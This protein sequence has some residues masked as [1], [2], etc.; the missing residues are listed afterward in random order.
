MTVLTVQRAWRIM[1]ARG[2]NTGGWRRRWRGGDCRRD[3]KWGV[4]ERGGGGG[5]EER[6]REVALRDVPGE[7][8][9]GL[10]RH[11]SEDKQRVTWPRPAARYGGG[12][13]ALA[14]HTHTHTHT[15]T[16]TP[17]R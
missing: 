9:P 15:A 10:T 7:R 1:D 17:S 8:Q 2:A 11:L 6:G 16:S 12:G 13:R 5:V 4:E 3:F 14:M